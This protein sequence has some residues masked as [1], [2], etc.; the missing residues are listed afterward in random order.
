MQ[1][2]GEQTSAG[3]SALRHF[4]RCACRGRRLRPEGRRGSLAC[5]SLHGKAPR[6]KSRQDP[7]AA[8]ATV[9]DARAWTQILARYRQP[10]TGR[11]VFE[12]A[13]TIVPLATLWGL[14]WVTLDI[15]YWL[16]LPLAIAAAGFL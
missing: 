4:A 2:F 13:I 11:S 10:S 16:A 8:A 14:A 9:R 12:I 1:L 6:L 3:A 5:A 7:A 15:G